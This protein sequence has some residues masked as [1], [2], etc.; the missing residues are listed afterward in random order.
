MI[1]LTASNDSINAN[2]DFIRIRQ[3]TVS[4]ED[5]VP[6]FSTTD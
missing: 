4:S 1:N 3:E 2:C 6:E 5:T